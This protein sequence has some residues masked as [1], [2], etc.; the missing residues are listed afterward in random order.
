MV[1]DAISRLSTNISLAVS[2][3][4]EIHGASEVPAMRCVHSRS[5]AAQTNKIEPHDLEHGNTSF[6]QQNSMTLV[7]LL[8][9]D[10]MMQC[11][12]VTTADG[13]VAAVR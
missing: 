9:D 5:C 7:Y 11:T 4:Q 12:L 10:S 1:A 8:L 2:R 6:S 3:R 13:K